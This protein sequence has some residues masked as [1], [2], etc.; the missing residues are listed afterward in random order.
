MGIKACIYVLPGGA[1]RIIHDCSECGWYSEWYHLLGSQ[2]C[3]Y[4]SKPR[5]LKK[6][7]KPYIDT[8]CELKVL[9]DE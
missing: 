5:S 9:K 7:V 8:G 1:I 4:K 2:A 3:L 6:W